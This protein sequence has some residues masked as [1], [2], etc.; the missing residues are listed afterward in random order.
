MFHFQ[1]QHYPVKFKRTSHDM[2]LEAPFCKLIFCGRANLV[3]Y[4]VLACGHFTAPQG[5]GSPPQNTQTSPTEDF[6][7]F[8]RIFE[9]LEDSRLNI[10][11][12]LFFLAKS[13]Y[14]DLKT[15]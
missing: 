10:D 3:A 9:R 14:L 11:E 2:I 4:L 12:H 7:T 15:L 5:V 1:Q 6:R 8:F 13:N